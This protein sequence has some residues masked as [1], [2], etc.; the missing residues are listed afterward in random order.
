MEYAPKL[1]LVVLGLAGL[2]TVTH[3][4]TAPPLSPDQQ[5]QLSAR[6]LSASAQA[7]QAPAMAQPDA[8]SLRMGGPPEVAGRPV[9]RRRTTKYRIDCLDC[10]LAGV[11]VRPVRINNQGVVAANDLSTG[12]GYVIAGGLLTPTPL[13]P[14]A[15]SSTVSDINDAGHLVGVQANASSLIGGYLGWPGGIALIPGPDGDVIRPSGIN[16]ADQVSASTFQHAVVY[17]RGVAHALPPPPG[18]SIAWSTGINIA[19]HVVGGSYSGGI[20]ANPD[21]WKYANGAIAVLSAEF[22]STYANAV[23]DLDEVAGS[24]DSYAAYW[25]ASGR[26]Q[27]LNGL[28]GFSTGMATALNIHGTV[29]GI[30]AA[31]NS[32]AYPRIAFVW[33][34]G[35]PY[36]LNTLI[37][38]GSTSGWMLNEADSI[39]D[40]GVIVGVGVLQ[41]QSHAFIA[42]PA[43]R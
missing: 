17:A 6:R 40:R 2:C 41:G 22:V 25:N 28:P 31:N 29:V 33:D 16:A 18:Q 38:G 23:N 4:E 32:S 3:A 15:T 5:Q 7:L 36:D 10:S 8:G 20:Y 9:E 30:L 26:L 27:I 13:V 11:V 21:G 42:T 1:S 43:S 39:N 37:Q 24:V 12:Q 14:G 35:K 19:G 34:G